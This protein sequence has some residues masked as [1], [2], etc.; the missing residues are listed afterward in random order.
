MISNPDI[1]YLLPAAFASG[2]IGRICRIPG[3]ALLCSTIGVAVVTNVWNFSHLVPGDLMFVLQTLIGSMLGQTIN[4][5]FW[6]DILTTWQPSVL[7]VGTFT[8]MAIPFAALL[9][10][11]S[12][13]DPLTATLAATPARMQDVIILAGA[14][15]RDAVTVM[16]MQLLRQMCIIV[17]TP[18]ILMGVRRSA[19]AGTTDPAARA[20]LKK[21]GET[22]GADKAY[23]KRYAYVFLLAP[24]FPGAFVGNMSGHPLGPL[25]GAFLAVGISRVVSLRAGE[26]PFPRPLT[27]VI[28]SL[29]G[30]LL[31]VRVTPDVGTLIMSR[32][33]PLGIGVVYIVG[34]GLLITWMLQ[35]RFGWSRAQSWISAAPG[36]TS[37]MLSI[38]QDLNLTG[39]DRL[40]LVAVHA[41]RQIYFTLVLA[42][43]SKFFL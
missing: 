36:R 29:A 10:F 37:D 35:R 33:M 12:G 19:K 9:V 27:Y 24:A 18:F 4:R 26:V 43:V 3:G 28:Q 22:F 39:R 11:S 16:L 25:L 42:V 14:T 21:A 7:V 17:M 20:A 32:L 13:F 30:L 2:F 15:D 41:I 6:H 8:V 31:G 1:I 5:R 34:T 40:A 23:L 38:S